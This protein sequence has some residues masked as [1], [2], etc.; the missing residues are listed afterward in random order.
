MPHEMNILGMKDYEIKEIKGQHQVVISVRYTGLIQCPHCEGERLRLKD[1]FIRRLR[2]EDWGMREC[3]LELESHKY[4]CHSCNRYFNQ[5]FPGI[6]PRRRNTEAFRRSVY[7][8]HLDGID[9][10]T[11]AK[12]ERIAPATVERWFHNFLIRA[13]S[14]RRDAPCPR[15]LGIDEHFFSRKKGFATTFCDLEHHRVYDVALGRSEAALE[16]YLKGLKGREQ[17]KVV[18][19]DLSETYRSIITKYFPRALIVADRFHVIRLIN[20]HFLTLWRFLDPSGS[21]NRGLLSLMRRHQ[22]NLSSVQSQRLADYLQAFPALKI[23]YDFKQRLTRLLLIK[24]RTARQC[25]Q[26]IPM[27]LEHLR[28]LDYSHFPLLAQLG[29]T[30]RSWSSEIVRMWRFTKNNGITE[31]FHTKMEMIS[32]RAFGFRNFDNYR[33]RVRVVCA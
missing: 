28:D 11:L 9:R 21:R 25:R 15:V 8:K 22:Q 10:Q 24:H 16:P 14:E 33:L 26:L 12:R 13:A 31:G 18:C 19:M 29:R 4:L 2:H 17:V 6:M 5:R 23:V 27:W 3:W 32:R 7:F 30:L 1:S 20:H